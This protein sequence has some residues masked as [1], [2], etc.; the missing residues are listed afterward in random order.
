MSDPAPI[1]L[2]KQHGLD[3]LRAMER[4]RRFEDRAAELYTAM[5]IRGFLHLYNGEEAV[6]VGVMG[7]LRPGDAVIATY[8][9]H[10]HALAAGLPMGAV[11]AELFGKVEGSSGG[12][13]GA[14]HIFDAEHRFYG[15]QAI[16]A[17]GLPMAVGLALAD[18]MQERAR[19]SACFFG[20]G[21][22]AEGEFHESLNLAALWELPVL[23]ICENNLYAMG[24]ALARSQA[25]TDIH[26]RAASYGVESSV[27]D[28]MDVLAVEAAAGAAAA[29]IRRDQRPRFIECR[30]YRFRAHS[31]FDAQLYRSREEVERWKQRC[32]ILALRRRLLADGLASDEEVAVI[33]REVAGE[34]EQAVAFAE[35]G[36]WEPVETLARHVTAER[37]P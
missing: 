25:V 37:A 9:E 30:T 15:G 7:G 12:R 24:T 11:M 33:E 32:P 35:A 1:A 19:V 29:A 34:V 3:L 10:G 28:G 2:C 5:K 26:A 18:R 8:R 36:T 13:G 21:A 14:M 4:I 17:G 20:E 23:F 27:V 6:A 16:V 31:M 22:A